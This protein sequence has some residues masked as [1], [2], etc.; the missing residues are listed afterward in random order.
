ME[1]FTRYSQAILAHKRESKTPSDQLAVTKRPFAY[2]SRQTLQELLNKK[3][4]VK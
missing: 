2:R 4:T 1:Q 3:P